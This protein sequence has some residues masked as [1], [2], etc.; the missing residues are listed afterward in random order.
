[1]KKIKLISGVTVSAIIVSVLIFSSCSKQELAEQPVTVKKEVKMSEE[2]IAVY[3]KILSFKKKVDYI[4]ENPHYKSGETM[5][6]DSAKW[7]LDASFN[8]T[9]AFTMDT[10]INFNTET[11]TISINKAEGMVNLDDVSAAF[12]ELKDKTL[13]IY[14]ATE[15]EEKELYVSHLDIVSN[16]SDEL[17]METTATIGSKTNEEPPPFSQWGPFEEGDDWMYGEKLG[18]CT[19]GG[20]IWWGLK[21][22]ATEMEDATNT[23]RYK[24]IQDEGSGWS[25]FYTE[26]SAVAV[27][28]VFDDQIVAELL[29]NPNDDEIDNYRDYLLLYQE[30]D[31]SIGLIVETC[32]P[33]EDMNFYYHGTHKVIYEIIQENY[34]VFGV[35]AGLTFYN[36]DLIE[37]VGV[38][39]NPYDPN[40]AHH[41]VKAVYKTRHILG[42][43][44]EPTSIGE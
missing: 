32:I 1:M 33:W 16:A 18:D 6:V 43:P 44:N 28:T 14:N 41:K 31:I 20:G 4:K 5:S 2:D 13:I 35:H 3:N 36:C 22:A 38:G 23:Y 17:I 40:Y 7:Y 26:P 27:V 19:T 12:Y 34:N 30:K 42:S 8:L 24:Y 10:F 39:G 9:Y 11:F 21:D 37:G 25:A 15:G 29:L